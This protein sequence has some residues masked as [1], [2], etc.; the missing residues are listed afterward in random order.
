MD[1]SNENN[2]STAGCCGSFV[3]K[4]TVSSYF[5]AT[6]H[7]SVLLRLLALICI[8]V[9]SATA[10]VALAA[11]AYV[12]NSDST[13][14]DPSTGLTW[15]RCSMGQTWSGTTCTGTI[16]QYTFVNANALSGTTTFAGQSDW[17]LPNIRELQTIVDRTGH[18]PAIDG[19]AF[20]ATHTD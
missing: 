5:F 2:W 6:S 4:G 17:R 9:G 15:M 13:V 18:S 16:R 20:P 12:I 19:T 1:W 8:L 7:H 3:Y 11:K 14:T 10:N